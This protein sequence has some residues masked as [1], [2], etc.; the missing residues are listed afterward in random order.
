MK[1]VTVAEM[2]AI[3]EE[4]NQKGVSFAM[5]MERA[6]KGVANNIQ[7]YFGSDKNKVVTALVGN[8]NNGGD[9]LVALELLAKSGW[10]IQA[11]LAK[12]RDDS[13]IKRVKDI[14]GSIIIYSD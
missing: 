12:D 6:G 7:N 1:L 8:G 9:A 3:E 11:F 2:R 4:A 14:G 13:L 5:M 10:T